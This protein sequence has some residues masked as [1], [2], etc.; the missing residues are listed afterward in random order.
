MSLS[1]H[2]E[3][4]PSRLNP[5]KQ[6]NAPEPDNPCSQTVPLKDPANADHPQH[7]DP[8]NVQRPPVPASQFPRRQSIGYGALHLL[9]SPAGIGV[10][11][12]E[13][14]PSLCRKACV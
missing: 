12:T 6:T 7:S 2:P 10:T 13:R 4:V 11:T 8:L 5:V 9:C 3:H 1:T 14:Q